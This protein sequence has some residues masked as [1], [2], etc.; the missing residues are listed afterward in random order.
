LRINRIFEGT[1]QVMRLFIA[2]EALDVHLRVAGDVVMPGVPTGRRLS[3]LVRSGWFYARWYPARWFGW[4][5]WP[6][7]SEFGG[8]AAH[9]RWVERTS[10]RLARTQF[11]LM[12]ANGPALEKKQALLFRCVD[13]G[14]ELFAMAAT[15]VRAQRDM[16]QAGMANAVELA[17]LFCQNARRKVEH[18]FAGIRSHSDPQA[19]RLAR[20]V[21][22]K[23]YAWLE[24]G[25]VNAPEAPAEHRETK[26]A[27]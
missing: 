9:L 21:L 3:G 12:M 23:R 8:L 19:Y 25:I 5:G 24:E 14:A 10:R 15:C 6:R 17:D 2:R 4:S 18:L 22:D 13:I 27:S 20:G 11:H 7:Y 16:K 1:N 26:A